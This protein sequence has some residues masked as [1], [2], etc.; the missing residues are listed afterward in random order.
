MT[1][2]TALAEPQNQVLA[3]SQPFPGKAY[4]AL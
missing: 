2:T 3:V 4:C 1:M